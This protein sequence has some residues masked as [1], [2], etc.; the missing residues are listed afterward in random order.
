MPNALTPEIGARFA[1]VALG[2]VTREYPNKPG[3]VL[4]G[5]ADARTPAALHPVFH[6]SYDWHSCVHGYWLLARVLR[7]FPEGVQAGAIRTLLDGQLT[8]EK[9]AGECAYFAAPTA[10]GY[11]RPYGWAWL[12]KLADELSRLP[13][14][15]WAEALA[16]LAG[17]I[18]QRVRDFLPIAPYPVR[19]GTHFNTAFA[20]RLAADYA[21]GARDAGLSDLLRGTAERWYGADMDCPAWGEPGGDD[22][23]SSALI[24]AECL[25]R[26]LPPQEFRPWF[27]RFLPDLAAGRPATLFRPATVTDRSDGK[28]A[29]LDGLNLSRAWCFRAL[30]AALDPDDPRRPRLQ[31]AAEAHLEAGL[32]H[33]TG[34]YMGEHWLATFALL[35]LDTEPASGPGATEG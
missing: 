31:S 13:E 5:P 12:L 10:R 14:R 21:E 30:A 9:V 28:I 8:P 1:A 16:P 17:L 7:L 24:E 2:H 15:R 3:H 34:D 27:D 26:L 18:A 19:V 29:H 11:E 35:A 20:L 32:P 22:F 25:R 33:V 23:L 6:G 4:A